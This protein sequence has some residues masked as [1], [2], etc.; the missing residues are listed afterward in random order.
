[1]S[2]ENN[3]KLGRPKIEIDWDEF[4]KLCNIQCTL[5]EISGWFDCSEDT[6]ERRVKEEKGIIFAEYYRQKASKGKISL[7]R[8]Q[9]KKALE[10]NVV[11]QIWLGKQYLAQV[12]KHETTLGNSKDGE[13]TAPFQLIINEP[14]D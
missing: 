9:V 14:K 13:L 1:M 2:E 5:S 4:D 3:S 11:M 6:I 7:R 10:G 8:A 12:D